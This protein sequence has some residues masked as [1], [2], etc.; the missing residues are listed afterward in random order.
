[1]RVQNCHDSFLVHGH[2]IHPLK[3]HIWVESAII[4]TLQVVSIS[5]NR[6]RREEEDALVG[7]SVGGRKPDESQPAL[8]VTVLICQIFPLLGK[9]STKMKLI[10]EEIG[11][12]GR[13]LFIFLDWLVLN[14]WSVQNVR[15][16]FFFY[17]LLKKGSLPNH[18][19]NKN[20]S[21]STIFW[22]VLQQYLW[23]VMSRE[24]SLATSRGKCR[25][26]A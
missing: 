20:E 2:V 26:Q 23:P 24:C 7:G 16:V 25:P 4:W 3:R 11:Q 13:M 21:C 6:G 17:F 9:I 8:N 15:L 10:E 22:A 1:M 19:G 14:F 18:I 5:R 12:V